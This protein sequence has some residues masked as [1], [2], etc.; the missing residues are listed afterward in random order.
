MSCLAG[1]YLL[2]AVIFAW[3]SRP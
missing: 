2:A 1:G 3:L